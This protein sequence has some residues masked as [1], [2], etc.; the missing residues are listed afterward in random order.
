ML[1]RLLDNKISSKLLGI[2]RITFFLNYLF[3]I[4]RIFRFKNLIYDKVPY[5]E[6]AEISFTYPLVIWSISVVFIIIGYK[7]RLFSLINYILSLILIGTIG[8]FEYHMFYAYMGIS[9]LA[10]FIPLSKSYSID[11]L[12]EKLN[13]ST[14]KKQ[15]V[16]EEKV[17]EFYYYFILFAGI[18]LVYFDS[19]F[20][21]LTSNLW[22]GGLG[23]WYPASMPIAVNLDSSI[24]LNNEIFIKYLGYLTIVFELVFIFLFWKKIFK[25]PFFILGLGL[26][27]GILILF[28][29]PYFAIGVTTMYLLILPATLPEKIKLPKVKNPLLFFYDNECPLCLRTKIVIE[30]FDL[31]K[32]INFV[33]IQ[34]NFTK[35][36]EIEKIGYNNA[37]NN[38]YSISNNKVH[39]G[40]DTY[41]AVLV[42]MIYTV[43]FALL[44]KIPG[45]YHLAKKVYSIVAANR[46]TERCDETSCQV[47]FS[48]IGNIDDE[49]KV[50]LFKNLTVTDL[51]K[52]G[53]KA[54]F[55]IVIFFQVFTSIN[56]PL[57]LRF[58]RNNRIYD[59][60]EKKLDGV[61]SFSRST[62]GITNHGVFMDWHFK[63]YNHVI[64]VEYI[65]SNNQKHILPFSTEKGMPGEYIK[66]FNWVNWTFRVNSP[67]I[68]QVKMI[69]GFKNY[70]AYWLHNNS[71]INDPKGSYTFLVSVKKIA[72]PNGWE[73]DFLK[74]QIEKPWVEAGTFTWVNGKFNSSLVKI[75]SI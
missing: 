55:Y 70:S 63:E 33:S 74:N 6:P 56:S 64:K 57:I 14:L 34:E 18:G 73:K 32:A 5:F 16:V 35:Y 67:K 71:I 39:E 51:K 8:S 61:R 28:P 58:V 7:T 2:F 38:I 41:I 10:L 62:M 31:F 36:P 11:N 3:E 54:L 46:N 21:K 60:Y 68:N 44:L 17:P 20:Y 25:I 19:I 37:L 27:I 22:M 42:K 69:N 24:V 9:F 15:H 45:I 1:N 72:S 48:S 47:G 53:F 75:E 29:I 50:K 23:T 52:I 30:H 66:G 12:I 13:Y 4:L 43:P 59:F 65:D 40:V 49:N 26:H